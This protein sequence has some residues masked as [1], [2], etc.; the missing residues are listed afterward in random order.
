M[1][2]VLRKVFIWFGIAAVGIAAAAPGSDGVAEK[3]PVILL[4]LDDLTSKGLKGS[5]PVRH[6]WRILDEYLHGLKIPYA[7]GVHCETFE[8]D[9]PATIDWMKER[10]ERGDV[11]FW[12]HGF[13]SARATR[14]DGT[15]EPGEFECSYEEQ[16][17][18]LRKCQDLAKEKLGVPLRTFGEH[19]SGVNEQTGR[20][21]AAIPEFEIWLYSYGPAGPG[22]ISGKYVYPRYMSIEYRTFVPK[23][24]EFRK[25]WEKVGKMQ[26]VLVLQGHP[27]SWG[28]E[29]DTE[30]WQEFRKIID[31]LRSE[32]C[33]FS[34]P[35]EY[36]HNYG[37]KEMSRKAK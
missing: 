3:T 9:H 6:S 18:T 1:K 35:S 22:E 14:P 7:V 4:K 16:Y 29:P 27:Q 20:A 19:W 2:N 10:I 11:E 37:S 31:F 26:P 8:T 12:C 34:T 13:A 24:D 30:R 21:L 23:L 28:W 33:T 36:Y 32:G 17:A 15:L 5:T 25:Q